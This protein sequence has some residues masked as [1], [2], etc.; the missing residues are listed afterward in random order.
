MHCISMQWNALQIEGWA[1]R[2]AEHPHALIIDL[3]TSPAP[4]VTLA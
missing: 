2:I 4:A 1:L 3:S